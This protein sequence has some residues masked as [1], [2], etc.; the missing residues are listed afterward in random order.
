M[1]GGTPDA[2]PPGASHWDEDVMYNLYTDALL[3]PPF[4]VPNEPVAGEN[5]R[6]SIHRP[7]LAPVTDGG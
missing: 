7:H 3:Y 5:N 4:F 6:R 2:I 1:N